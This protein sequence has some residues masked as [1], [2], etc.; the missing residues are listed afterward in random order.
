MRAQSLKGLIEFSAIG[1]EILKYLAGGRDD[2]YAI[3]WPESIYAVTGRCSS[4]GEVFE[5]RVDIVEQIG[6]VAGGSGRR[7]FC[8]SL[9]GVCLGTLERGSGSAHIFRLLHYEAL[10]RLWSAIVEEREV[11][12]AKISD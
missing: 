8:E 7:V 2:R 4:A 10:D 5:A 11:F 3:F 9:R 12:F 1:S 6:D